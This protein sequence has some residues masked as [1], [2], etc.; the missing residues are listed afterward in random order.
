MNESPS[1]TS[2]ATTPVASQGPE[3]HS[4]ASGGEESDASMGEKHERVQVVHVTAGDAE[5]NEDK[6]HSLSGATDVGN[7]PEIKSKKRTSPVVTKRKSSISLR[8]DALDS[9]RKQY[10]NKSPSNSPAHSA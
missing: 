10:E 1:V 6:I 3:I 8:Y 4:M 9:L 2:P 5:A 7:L